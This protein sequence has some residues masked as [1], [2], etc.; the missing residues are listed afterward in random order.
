MFTEKELPEFQQNISY[1]FNDKSLLVL[2]LTHPS[3]HQHDKTKPNNQRL[4]FLGDS[5]LSLLLTDELY[6]NLPDA[7][8]GE[9][10]QYR[11]SLIRG[12]SLAKLARY[13]GIQNYIRLSP[14]EQNNKG[15]QRQSTLEDA[16]EA[17]IGAIYLDGGIVKTKELVLDWMLNLWGDLT[18]NL[19]NHNPKGKIQ[20]WVQEN[21][22]SAR[23]KYKIIGESGPDHARY[24]ESEIL[25]NNKSY[26]TGAGNSKKEAES[27]AAQA[28]VALLCD[29]DR[30]GK[31]NQVSE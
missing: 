19:S 23:I 2:A 22:P 10:T 1:Q 15:S 30:E 27:K 6:T 3:F 26:G 24:F 4:E 28:A 16:M 20:E 13:L 31:L 9:L 18:D 21:M 11:A 14:S 25:I 8:E 17:L 29:K 5:V 12:E 7:N